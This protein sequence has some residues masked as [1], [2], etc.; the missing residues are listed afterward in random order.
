[1]S[2]QVVSATTFDKSQVNISKPDSKPNSATKSSDVTYGCYKHFDIKFPLMSVGFDLKIEEVAVKNQDPANPE[3]NTKYQMRLSFDKLK[4]EDPK[5]HAVKN[6]QKAFH[7]MLNQC[8]DV[9]V[10]TIVK[11]PLEWLKQKTVTKAVVEKAF[12]NRSVKFSK[13][14][15]S[16]VPNG[17]YDDGINVRIPYYKKNDNFPVTFLDANNEEISQTD[18]ISKIKLG[19]KVMGIIRAGVYYANSKYGFNFMLT[20]I[21]IMSEGNKSKKLP[22][23]IHLVSHS[24]DDS[25]SEE[26]PHPTTPVKTTEDLDTKVEDSKDDLDGDDTSNHSE[27]EPEP[28]PEPVKPARRI[29]RKTAK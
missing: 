10:E 14:K 1:M 19:A 17:K 27:P 28:E 3:T 8:D 26:M 4:S 25:D 9:L 15:G 24:D 18:G 6:R 21:R 16:N 12:I 20:A 2:E 29:I 23:G 11:N 13:D 7:A 22:K 5:D